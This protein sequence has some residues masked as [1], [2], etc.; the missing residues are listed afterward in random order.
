MKMNT[1]IFFLSFMLLLTRS[2][3]I[4]LRDGCTL[5]RGNYDY[6]YSTLGEENN[7]K[8][9]EDATFLCKLLSY[10]VSITYAMLNEPLV[11]VSDLSVLCDLNVDIRLAYSLNGQRTSCYFGIT[12]H[13]LDQIV[14]T[15]KQEKWSGISRVVSSTLMLSA[16]LRE[17]TLA[18][19]QVIDG[20]S[21]LRQDLTPIWKP[22]VALFFIFTEEVGFE[23]CSYS[24]ASQLYSSRNNGSKWCKDHSI[25][26]ITALLE[27]LIATWGDKSMWVDLVLYIDYQPKV[28]IRQQRPQGKDRSQSDCPPS[29]VINCPEIL[30]LLSD[31]LS[32]IIN[33][34]RCVQTPSSCVSTDEQYIGH[35]YDLLVQDAYD[36]GAEY[37][38]FPA[39][40]NSQLNYFQDGWLIHIISALRGS[41]FA[42]NVGV[43]IQ[44]EGCTKGFSTGGSIR[45]VKSMAFHRTHIDIIRALSDI[46]NHDTKRIAGYALEDRN[47]FGH[48]SG[49]GFPETHSGAMKWDGNSSTRMNKLVVIEAYGY[50]GSIICPSPALF[51]L[52]ASDIDSQIIS[53]EQDVLYDSSP[54]QLGVYIDRVQTL[55]LSI[56]TWVQS[57]LPL[58]NVEWTE[59]M[60]AYQRGDLFYDLY[61]SYDV[62]GD[63]TISATSPHHSICVQRGSEKVADIP[64]EAMF[65]SSK[66]RAK[67]VF[68]TAIYGNYEKTVKRFVR[69]TIPTDFICFTDNPKIRANGWIVDTI[70]YHDLIQHPGKHHH[71]LYSVM[72][73]RF[74]HI[75]TVILRLTSRFFCSE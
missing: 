55:R 72:I 7:K 73:L 28:Q 27:Q 43:V 8:S 14:Q 46:N 59:E 26:V 40:S 74:V 63:L 18:D 60:I 71:L 61:C 64:Y 44:G 37:F 58:L 50:F 51:D 41:P 2:G 42:R 25:H 13:V 36:T 65:Q 48:K 3:S 38:Y 47:R 49:E 54:F 34:V 75:C 21:H 1:L 17:Y 33:G 45:E 19:M 5:Q 23:S 20:F 56:A 35:E 69:Q 57:H 68:I 67:I 29:T 24:T 16:F 70:P 66:N 53:S 12:F 9:L 22:K 11:L 10:S 39:M 52:T 15:A 6:L 31:D 4:N 62:I 30:L 32:G